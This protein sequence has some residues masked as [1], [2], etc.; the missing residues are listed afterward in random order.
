MFVLSVLLLLLPQDEYDT[1]LISAVLNIK[2]VQ[3]LAVYAQGGM[4]DEELR[5]HL[6]AVRHE[7]QADVDAAGSAITAGVDKTI[8]AVESKNDSDAVPV[9]A[10]GND[11]GDKN[12]E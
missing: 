10:E 8:P 5:F 12:S 3:M 7:T 6:T 9:A 4:D 11:D 2:C 1:A